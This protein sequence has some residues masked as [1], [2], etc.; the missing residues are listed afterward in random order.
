M[1]RIAKNAF[2]LPVFV[3]L[4]LLAIDGLAERSDQPRSVPATPSYGHHAVSTKSKEAQRLFDQGLGLIYALD[5]NEAAKVV[6]TRCHT[7]SNHGDGLIGAYLMLWV[8]TTTITRPGTHLENAKPTRRY[9]VPVLYRQM[10]LKLNGPISRPSARGTVIARI[11]TARSW[12]SSLRMPCAIW[13]KLILT[14]STRR[15]FTLKAS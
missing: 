9:S 2:L 13:R 10:D 5:Y 6:P 14:T 4:F 8:R 11:R 7:G 12:Q 3:F 15:R 1:D